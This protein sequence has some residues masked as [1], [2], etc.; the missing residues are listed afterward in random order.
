MIIF[1]IILTLVFLIGAAIGFLKFKNHRY[2]IAFE[3]KQQLQLIEEQKADA[4]I[5]AAE[6]G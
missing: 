1:T 5:K 2:Q 3:K 4:A 6:N